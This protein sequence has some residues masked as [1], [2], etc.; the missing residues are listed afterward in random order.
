M[1]K[2]TRITRLKLGDDQAVWIETQDVE[3]DADDTEIGLAGR[4]EAEHE[5]RFQQAIEQIRP[6]A[7]A[8]FATLRDIN[9][10]KEIELELGIGFSGKIGAF[11]ASADTSA[12]FKIKLKWSNE[13]PA[14]KPSS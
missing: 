11:I 9:S 6:A 4:D 12:T 2:D 3:L 5:R 7:E 1:G 10:P 8:I 14:E 13:R